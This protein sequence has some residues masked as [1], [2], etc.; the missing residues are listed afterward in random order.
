MRRRQRAVDDF[1]ATLLADSVTQRASAY[2]GAKGATPNAAQMPK[3]ATSPRRSS[4]GRRR[5]VPTRGLPGGPTCLRRG[6]VCVTSP[7]SPPWAADEA[8]TRADRSRDPEAKATLLNVAAMYDAMADRAEERERVSRTEYQRSTRSTLGP[9]FDSYRRSGLCWTQGGAP[10]RQNAPV[11]QILTLAE[12]LLSFCRET[13]WAV[14]ATRLTVKAN[15]EGEMSRDG[16]TIEKMEQFHAAASP[17][18]RRRPAAA[19]PRGLGDKSFTD[20]VIAI[21]PRLMEV[22]LRGTKSNVDSE[23]IVSTTVVKML[24]H[25]NQFMPGSNFA[26]WAITI[27]R[28]VFLNGV[29][30]ARVHV[31]LMLTGPNGQDFDRPEMVMHLAPIQESGIVALEM[32][33]EVDKLPQDQQDC[34]KRAIYDGQGYDQIAQETRV[35]EGTVKSRIS[36]ARSTLNSTEVG[37]IA[38][39]YCE[40]AKRAAS[41]RRAARQGQCVN[42]AA[43]KSN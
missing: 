21:R 22:A 27:T 34:L 42:G 30:R 11:S 31:P 16:V 7:H 17:T 28:N 24:E 14:I 29:A 38:P 1:G 10:A 20:M 13:N 8:R 4:R 19:P 12:A 23:D 5:P 40:N 25:K 18:T 33:A 32:A 15:K 3:R 2:V 43:L 9:G 37:V 26:A 41:S 39:E 36:R 6:G 35:S